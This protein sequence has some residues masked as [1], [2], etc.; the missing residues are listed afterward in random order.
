VKYE[1]PRLCDFTVSY[2]SKET[3]Y[4][5][6]LPLT[7]QQILINFGCASTY[8]SNCS[9]KVLCLRLTILYFVKFYLN[10]TI[11][12]NICNIL[13]DLGKSLGSVL[14]YKKQNGH[15]HR[16]DKYK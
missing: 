9:E 16:Y 13:Q 2:K 11:Y 12:N 3:V 8:Y 15:K 14:A 5:T 4:R 1:G 7:L 6:N 10:L